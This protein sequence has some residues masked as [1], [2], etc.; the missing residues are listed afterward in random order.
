MK[1]LSNVHIMLLKLNNSPL[2]CLQLNCFVSDVYDAY[3][4]FNE[5]CLIKTMLTHLTINLYS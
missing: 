5:K 3:L 2:L 4:I 1:I